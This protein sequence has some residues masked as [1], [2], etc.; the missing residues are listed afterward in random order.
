MAFPMPHKFKMPCVD[1]YDGNRDPTEYVENFR[2]HLIL[3]GTPYEIACRAFLLTLAGVA[4]DW[5]ARLP[6]KVGGQLQGPWI[7]LPSLVPC[8]SKKKE[9]P[10]LLDVPSS[11]EGGV[12][13]GFYAPI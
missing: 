11:R 1:K 6:P 7:P 4:K 2:A 9:E 8:D 13:E 5:F 10:C 12:F 3:H